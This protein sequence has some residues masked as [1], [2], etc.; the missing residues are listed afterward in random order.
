MIL[1]RTQILLLFL[2]CAC[3]GTQ[4]GGRTPDS[5]REAEAETFD[6]ATLGEP[7][8]DLPASVGLQPADLDRL[9]AGEGRTSA[10]E[11]QKTTPGFRV[12]LISTREEA[13]ARLLRRDALLAFEE[14]VYLIYDDPY[15]KLRVG[16]CLSR[17]EADQ[18]Q[19]AAVERGFLE[20]WVVRTMVKPVSSPP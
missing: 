19:E 10:I 20:S 6:P 11:D 1:R 8:L 15:Y 14:N 16:D 12:Q 3:A 13:E 7:D 4:P 17:Y 2:F 5:G 18:L 9:L